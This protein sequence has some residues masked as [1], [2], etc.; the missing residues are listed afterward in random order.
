MPNLCAILYYGL[1]LSYYCEKMEKTSGVIEEPDMN[2]D[3]IFDLTGYTLLQFL[4]LPFGVPI[5]IMLKIKDSIMECIWVT[6]I[7]IAK[8]KAL[9]E[10]A[11]R[12]RKSF[13]HRVRKTLSRWLRDFRYAFIV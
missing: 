6:K 12:K 5:I 8:R 3:E 11:I 2:P 4:L 13:Y 10:E 7:W 1:N 9:R